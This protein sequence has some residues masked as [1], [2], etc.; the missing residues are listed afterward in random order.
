L[1]IPEGEDIVQPKE[2]KAMNASQKPLGSILTLALGLL[3][4][5]APAA[6]ATGSYG[7]FRVVEGSAT[8]MQAGNDERASAEINQPVL[9]GDR[10]W[11]PDRSRVEVVLADRNIVRL[12]GGS[13]LLLERLAASPDRDDRATVLR[14]LEGNLQLV[15][16]QDSLGDELPR[17][18][19]P[20][21]TIYPQ[22]FGV[23][24][25]TADREGWTELV[26]RTGT[27]EV[28]TDDGTVRVRADEQAIVDRDAQVRQA[29]GFDALE[30]W[31]RQLD[32]DYRS[33]DVR[34]VDD[35]LRY[36]AAPLARH[37]SWI[38]H[39]GSPYWRPR[40]AAGWRPYWQG[41]WIYTPSGMTW[42]SNEPWGWVPYHYGSWDYLPA[43][44]WAW[45]PGHVW[46]PAWVY[47]YW[48]PS[49]VG[50]CPT[51]YYTRYYGPRFGHNFGFRFGVYGWAGGHWGN[52]H[53][54]SFVRS[55]YFDHRAYRHGYRDGY[56]D[57][58]WDG[59]RDVHRYA[60][61]IDRDGR[62]ELERGIITTDTKPLR[63]STW[64]NQDEV[65]RA[66]RVAGPG[67]AE[68][69]DVTSFIARKPDLPASVTRVVRADGDTKPLDGTPLKPSTLGRGGDSR[70]GQIGGTAP[71]EAGGS[72]RI[73][74]PR[75]VIGDD[76]SVG[77][78]S[79]ANGRSGVRATPSDRSGR[80]AAEADGGAPRP[81]IVIEKP[82]RPEASKP[83][84][85][86]GDSALRER[87]SSRPVP[88]ADGGAPRPDRS[89]RVEAKPRVEAR[90]PADRNDGDSPGVASRP[91]S[92]RPTP[93]ADG[94]A[95]RPDRSGRVEAK[96]REE[97]RPP[98]D[99]GVRRY[100][101]PRRE[102]FVRPETS[103]RPERYRQPEPRVIEPRYRGP[104]PSQRPDPQPRYESRSE[105]RREAPAPRA[106]PSPRRDAPSARQAEPPRS[107]GD[108]GSRSQSRARQ[109][110]PPRDD[111]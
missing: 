11:V 106:E 37:G 101:A 98:A 56:R 61:D 20:N 41:R 69:P 34:Y 93:E 100:E 105:P 102:V 78:A 7:Y 75:V 4:L 55:S 22:N 5:S 66:L 51:G 50:W 87:P 35:N 79:G 91:R 40:V 57:G 90:P 82:D 42:V 81:R 24:R 45:Q 30:R 89:G 54:W 63:P 21:A 111:G 109:S 80:P 97:A 74:K 99:D 8:L 104:E 23:Y 85:R 16:I 65:R 95:P 46:S 33:A 43:Y 9:A 48:G 10:L 49:Y 68:L 76:G 29:G 31:A 1:L 28:V 67:A 32:D 14:L 15:V 12:D 25:I 64:R 71:G 83:S 72:A 2:T 60:V 39:D 27:A 36:S 108:Q 17:I 107:R 53:H 6:A 19:T 58:F 38:Y 26:V 96:P 86:D 103:D 59:R 70:S 44:G 110:R 84:F 77:G 92:A 18:E 52:F 13:E 3:A 47:W 88:E 94:G 73:G 62:G